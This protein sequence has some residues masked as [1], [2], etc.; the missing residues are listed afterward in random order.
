MAISSDEHAKWRHYKPAEVKVINDRAVQFRDVA[1]HEFTMSDVEDPDLWAAKPLSEW[2]DSEVG[3]WC[4]ANAEETPYW[5]R[6]HCLS[7]YGYKYLIVAR[8][9]EQNET[10]WRLL[11]SPK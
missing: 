8:F 4:I 2:A 9:S 3:K 6:Q 5:V 10:F 7:T 1:V 11:C